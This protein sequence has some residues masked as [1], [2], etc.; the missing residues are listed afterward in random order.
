MADARTLKLP[1]APTPLTPQHDLT[2]FQSGTPALD[3][4]LRRRAL[5]NQF[6]GATRTFVASSHGTG[7]KAEVVGFYSLA[8]GAI[9]HG[10][11]PGGVRRNMP[12]PVP[13]IVLARLAV[14]RAC[15]GKGLGAALLQDAVLRCLQVAQHTGVRALLVHA[16]DGTARAF[17]ARYGFVPSP[18][19]PMLLLLTLPN[20]GA[21]RL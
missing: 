12:D 1:A 10:L 9:A 2:T 13:V 21:G 5:P 6:T 4:W 19:Q 8:A 11:S 3:E 14:D 15:Q 20:G 17:Y 16:K 18:V 7:G